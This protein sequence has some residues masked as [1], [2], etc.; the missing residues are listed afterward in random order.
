MTCTRG[1][2]GSATTAASTITISNIVNP[3]AIA[4]TG[5]F[6]IE[7]TTNAGVPI[8]FANAATIS[9]YTA[10]LAA[11]PTVVPAAQIGGARESVTISFDPTTSLPNNGKIVITFPTGFDLSGTGNNEPAVTAVTGGLGTTASDVTCADAGQV[12]TCTRGGGGSATTAASTI[13]ISNI[14]NP[15][16]IASTGTFL[17]ETTTNAGVPIDFANAA[18]IKIYTAALTSTR[19]VV[20]ANL[21]PGVKGAATITFTAPT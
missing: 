10:A 1:G 17:I 6:L 16:A 5:T 4:S 21:H 15:S 7:T 14:V 9:I 13:T 11:T 2:G 3:S 8:D 12:M 18:T 20:P 19:T